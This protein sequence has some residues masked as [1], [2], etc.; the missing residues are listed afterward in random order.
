MTSAWND[1]INAARKGNLRDIELEQKTGAAP[2]A[3]KKLNPGLAS[4]LKQASAGADKIAA[5]LHEQEHAREMDNWARKQAFIDASQMQGGGGGMPPGGGMDPSMGGA[6][7][8]D[9][10]MGGAPPMDPSMMGGGM[11]PGGAPPMD[12]SMMGG[13]M[14]PMG[15]GM[16]PMGGGMDPSMMGGMMPPQ[17][18]MDPNGKKMKVEE[19]I[20][21]ETARIKELLHALFTAMGVEI[22]LSVVDSK[23]MA[24]AILE[25]EEKKR[26]EQQVEATIP[27]TNTMP[28]PPLNN[29]IGS[30]GP[31]TNGKAAAIARI[32]QAPDP[33]KPDAQKPKK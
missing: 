9:P 10:S 23:D 25:R 26:T 8:M 18:G 5:H 24:A 6:P 7:P 14:P 2:A 31:V 1:L 22:P 3:P 28:I 20:M 21:R 32:L 15:G 11:P 12:P 13:G 29:K 33:K 4:L 19:I 16:P 30:I 27:G 17:P